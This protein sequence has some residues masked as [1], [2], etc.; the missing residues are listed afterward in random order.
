MSLPQFPNL[1]TS[2]DYCECVKHCSS[3]YGKIFILK[4]TVVVQFSRNDFSSYC[5]PDTGYVPRQKSEQEQPHSHTDTQVLTFW[6]GKEVN[7][8]TLYCSEMEVEAG[9][10]VVLEEREVHSFPSPG[11]EDQ[12]KFPGG[13]HREP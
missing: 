11:K 4:I 5:V 12:G 9:Q 3:S 13:S 8:Q 7:R 2:W 10:A 6:V 1:S